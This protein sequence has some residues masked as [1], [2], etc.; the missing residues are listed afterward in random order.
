MWSHCSICP[1]LFSGKK[2]IKYPPQLSIYICICILRFYTHLAFPPDVFFYAVPQNMH[3]NMWRQTI[4][5]PTSRICATHLRT[6]EVSLKNRIMVNV[7]PNPVY[8][9]KRI[10][11]CHVTCSSYTLVF[12]ESQ[13]LLKDKHITHSQHAKCLCV[14]WPIYLLTH[15]QTI[16]CIFVAHGFNYIKSFCVCVK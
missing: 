3:K 7:Y 14:K 12:A 2:L 11:A 4:D 9:T 16:M 13:H 8:F 1:C 10:W 15:L 5:R 6:E